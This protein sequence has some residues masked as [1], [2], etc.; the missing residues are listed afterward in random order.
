MPDEDK[1]KEI[2]KELKGVKDMKMR[3]EKFLEASG[4]AESKVGQLT[5]DLEGIRRSTGTFFKFP[6]TSGTSSAASPCSR[7]SGSP[8]TRTTPSPTSATPYVARRLLTDPSPETKRALEQLL[9]GA[10]GLACRAQRAPSQE[11]AGAFGNYSAMTGAPNGGGDDDDLE[12]DGS[13]KGSV[14][15]KTPKLSKGAR[16]A[17]R[18]G[19]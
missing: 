14:R 19:V 1:I 15:P 9:Y 4:G 13:E 3:R 17:L 12:R 8:R 6:R 10:E 16:D 11:L 5:R 18:S 2:R 7:A